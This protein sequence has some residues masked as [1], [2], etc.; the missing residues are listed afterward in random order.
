M[1]DIR[2]ESKD[3]IARITIH[4]EAQGNSISNAVVQGLQAAW[5]RFVRDEADRAAVLCAAGETRFRPAPT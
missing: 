5:Q 2:Y 1:T 3:D 4:R